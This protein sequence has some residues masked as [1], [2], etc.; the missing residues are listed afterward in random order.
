MRK[1]VYYVAVTLD[2]FIAAPD[3][4]Y[5]FYLLEGDHMASIATEYPETIP[6]HVRRAL[7]LT[8]ENKH[9]DTVVMGRRTLDPALS[10]G[11]TSPW[12]HL[13]Q[14]VFSRSLADFHGENEPTVVRTEAIDA[15]RRLKAQDGLDIWLAGGGDL[16]GQLLP[17]IDELV[18]KINPIIIGTGIPLASADFTPH[19]FQRTDVITYDSGVTF[20]KLG[21]SRA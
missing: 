7:G 2:G 21:R 6:E 9:F 18:L 12:P 5:D 14:Y 20:M 16:A 17:E 8:H 15:V 1:L 11:L 19:T 10:A 3:G 13:R 4:T